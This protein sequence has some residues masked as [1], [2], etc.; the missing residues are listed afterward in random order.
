MKSM[1]SKEIKNR[2]GAFAEAARRET[3]V[4]T[5][6]GRPTLVTISIDRARKLP[7]LRE[8]LGGPSAAESSPRLDRLLRLGGSG[9]VFAGSPSPEDLAA[10]SRAFRGSE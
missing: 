5:S 1:S 7:G 9:A 10:R 6:H 3:I 4:H 8:E 2:Y